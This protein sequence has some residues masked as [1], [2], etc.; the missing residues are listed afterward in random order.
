MQYMNLVFAKHDTH[1]YPYPI[2]FAAPL[3]QTIKK[4]T[5]IVVKTRRGMA[6]AVATAQSFIAPAQTAKVIVENH[7]GYYPPAPVLA[8]I[9]TEMTPTRVVTVL[10]CGSCEDVEK[11]MHEKEN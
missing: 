2:L 7:G 6:E 8:T 3:D 10:D 9:Q 4:G 5:R 1:P 11:Y